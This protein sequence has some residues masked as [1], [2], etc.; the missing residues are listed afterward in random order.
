MTE[1]QDFSA[2]SQVEKAAAEADGARLPDPWFEELLRYLKESRGFDFTGYKRTS[3]MRRVNRQM[4]IV[5]VTSYED[6]RDYLELHPDEFTA[7]FNT[8]LI[9]VTSFFRDPDV[10]DHLQSEVL[11]AVLAHRA[12]D[13]IRV[14]SVGCATGEEAYTLA[15]VLAEAIGVEAFRRRV[16]IYATDVDE[17]ALTRARQ[18]TY[19]ERDLKGIPAELVEKY[20]ETSGQRFT[21]VKELRRSVIFGRNDLIQ[22]APISH[23]DILVCRNTLMYFNAEAQSKIVQRLHFALED[24]GVLFL[25]KAEMLLSHGALFT[26]LDLKRR[27]FSKV[28]RAPGRERGLLVGTMSAG[29]ISGQDD[30]LAKLRQEALNASPV[31]QIVVDMA[32]RMLLSNQQADQQFTL[33]TRHAGRPFQDLEISYRPV[34]L[35]SL[36]DQAQ[37]ERRPL[38]VR[39]VEWKRAGATSW[40]D[41]QIV[42]L[43][44][45]EG[46]MLGTSLFFTDVSRYRQLQGELEH[47]HRQLETAYEELQSTNEELETTNEELQ[48]TVE[49]LETTNE[50]LQ[51]T[52]EELETMN[53]ELQSMN[54]EL[55]SSNEELRDRTNQVSD[56]NQFMESVL[57]AMQTG[58]AVVNGDMQV[59]MWNSRAEELW[60]VRQ[61]E[62]VGQHLLNLDIGLPMEQLRPVVRAAITQSDVEDHTVVVVEAVNRRG[63]NITVTVTVSALRYANKQPSGALILMSVAD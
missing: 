39:D 24:T 62:T 52:N 58:V 27:F 29:S 54:D 18:A 35:R 43:L 51:S 49:E 30:Y 56:L 41:I 34:E 1:P 59:Q 13:P 44:D 14:W 25:G 19:V 46:T 5:S 53:E 6:Y 61:E 42:P 10:W 20:F 50:E 33:S 22:D 2:G 40:L 7:L 37:T 57:T 38:L 60:G 48:S 23:I 26:P 21:F 8:V 11:P 4:Q 55:Q 45:R 9:N 15:I 3:L 31:A 32:G 16:K 12:D 28:T 47:T 63:R 36:I 17:E